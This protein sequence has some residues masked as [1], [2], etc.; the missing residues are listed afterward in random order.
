MQFVAKKAYPEGRK[1]LG[2][3]RD[4][5]DIHVISDLQFLTLHYWAIRGRLEQLGRRNCE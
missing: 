4:R 2:I 3:A 1:D 5:V